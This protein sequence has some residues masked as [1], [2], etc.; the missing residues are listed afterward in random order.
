[1]ILFHKPKKA[2]I[3]RKCD[4]YTSESVKSTLYIYQTKYIKQKYIKPS[5]QERRDVTFFIIE[6]RDIK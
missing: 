5:F 2:F 1:M 6:G 3:H 4:F